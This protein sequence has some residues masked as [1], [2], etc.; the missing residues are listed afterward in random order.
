MRRFIL[1]ELDVHDVPLDR[2][3]VNLVVLPMC[4]NKAN[5]GNLPVVVHGNYEPI[6][7]TFDVENDAISG[8]K[9]ALR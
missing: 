9:L 5:V 3:Y 2:C 1:N 4:S 7:V 6:V 8:K